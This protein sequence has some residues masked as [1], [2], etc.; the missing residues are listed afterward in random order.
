MSD[1]DDLYGTR[2]L[3]A[4]ELKAPAT[5]TIDR[6]DEELF[7]RPGEPTRTKKVIYV[8]GGKKGIVINKTNASNL[9]AAFGKNFSAWVGKRITVKAELTTFAGKST[10][11]LRLYPDRIESGPVAPPEPPKPPVAA[12]M[13]DEI[14]W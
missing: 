14:P 11:G 7:A 3:S 9:A 6:I 1:Y 8:R 4:S 2:F 5:A 10:L 13:S 12:A